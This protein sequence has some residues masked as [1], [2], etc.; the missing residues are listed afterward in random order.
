M[1]VFAAA[2]VG[3]RLVAPSATQLAQAM[4]RHASATVL[5]FAVMQNWGVVAL[6]DRPYGQLLPFVALGLLLLVALPYAR[7][8]ERRWR[9]LAEAALP[10]GDLERHYRLDRARLWRGA[11]LLPALWIGAVAVLSLLVH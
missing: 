1:A 10:G 5:M 6:A 2:S 3:R 9:R 11:F 8:V 7:R 4:G